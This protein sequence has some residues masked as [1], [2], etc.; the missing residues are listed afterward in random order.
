MN[1][2]IAAD[3]LVTVIE[4]LRAN[5]TSLITESQ[6]LGFKGN[7]QLRKAL[8]AKLG[9]EG[10]D[11]LMAGHRHRVGHV[12][13][14]I[15][16]TDVPVVTS[17]PLSQ[18]WKLESITAGHERHDMFVSPDGIKYVAASGHEKADLIGKPKTPGLAP[19][20]LRR[21]E[22]S[23][24]ERWAKRHAKLVDQGEAQRERRSGFEPDDSIRKQKAKRVHRKGGK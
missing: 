16:D 22:Q 17:M 19:I 14:V 4:R 8:R 15:D 1:A 18:G 3:V 2:T 24:I 12:A 11:E 5:T 6:A 7:D 13:V 20:R 9:L 10:Y 21:L 23:R